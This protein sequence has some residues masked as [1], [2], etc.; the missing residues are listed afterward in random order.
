MF[1]RLK[2]ISLGNWILIGMVLGVIVGLFLN[3]YVNNHFIK[4]IILMDNVFYLG[5][6]YFYQIDEN[7]YCSTCFLFFSCWYNINFRYS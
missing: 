5:G 3:L 7:D 1:Y 2:K 6:Q 4:D